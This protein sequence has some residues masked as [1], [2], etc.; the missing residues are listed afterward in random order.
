[1][2]SY[3]TFALTK[4]F[5]VLV[6]RIVAKDAT[7]EVTLDG[8]GLHAMI[9]WRGRRRSVALNSLRIVLFDIAAMLC[10]VEGT[11]SAPAFL[12][13]D[14]PRE[15]DLDPWTYARLFETAFA[16]GHEEEN[17][18]FQYIITTTTEPPEGEIRGRVRT[19]L[20]ARSYE[21]RFFL[22]DL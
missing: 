9:Q 7:G 12:L 10:A 8:K 15:G 19:E 1:M 22:V 14:S 18:P 17:A 3:S 11:S 13:H 4:W 6:K 21:T 16:L 2:T 5:D 20:S